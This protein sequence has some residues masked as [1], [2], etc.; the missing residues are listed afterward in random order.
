MEKEELCKKI[1]HHVGMPRTGT[2]FLYFTL[3]QH[4]EVFLPPV[5]EIN[6]FNLHYEK[7]L[8]WYLNF[9]ENMSS[10]KLTLDFSPMGFLDQSYLEKAAQFSPEAHFILGVR[11]P[12]DFMI[13]L[14]KQFS[15]V[16]LGKKPSFSEFLEKG[17]K[18]IQADM[19]YQFVKAPTASEIKRRIEV[20]KSRL[21][22]KLF[23]YSYEEFE[24]NPLKLVQ[25]LESFLSLS[26]FFSEENF[27]NEKVNASNRIVFKPLVYLRANPMVRRFFLTF[28]PHQVIQ[29]L[30]RSFSFK[31][32]EKKK[33][34]KNDKAH[35]ELA[36]KVYKEADE[37]YDSLFLKKENL[38]KYPRLVKA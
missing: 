2:T 20:Y 1:V 38:S 10:E 19:D 3:G 21:G 11:R 14:Y 9:F 16:A 5:K 28:F 8:S 17:M 15:H 26:S 6:F 22:D 4:P 24:S 7:G 12:S 35:L 34:S 27:K 31:I 29:F 25:N 37:Y 36:Q 33:M 23:L 32:F 30:M 18:I 13:S